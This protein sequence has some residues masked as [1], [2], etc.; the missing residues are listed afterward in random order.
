MDLPFAWVINS[1]ARRLLLFIRSY[2]KTLF[3]E[4]KKYHGPSKLT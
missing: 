3:E 4:I 1:F 2:F